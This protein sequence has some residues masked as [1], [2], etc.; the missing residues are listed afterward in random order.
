MA[1]LM[2]DC[3]C[4]RVCLE[5]QLAVRLIVLCVLSILSSLFG[6]SQPILLPEMN[7]YV[8]YFVQ[9]CYD[10]KIFQFSTEINKNLKLLKSC[11]IFNEFDQ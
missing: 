6:I 11:D 4:H 1:W 9:K 7:L 2:A 3:M 10:F 8:D 5:I